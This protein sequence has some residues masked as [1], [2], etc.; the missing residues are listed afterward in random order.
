MT[1]LPCVPL[2][3]PFYKAWT[4]RFPKAY[5]AGKNFFLSR[6]LGE[7]GIEKEYGMQDEFGFIVG[8]LPRFFLKIIPRV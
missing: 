4:A 2:G 5:A 7:K 8:I 1:T 6:F 3:L